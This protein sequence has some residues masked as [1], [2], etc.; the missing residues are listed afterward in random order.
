MPDGKRIIVLNKES[1]AQDNVMTTAQHEVGHAVL[2]ETVKNKPEAAIALGTSLLEELKNSKDITFTSSRFLDRFNQYV[3]DA[4]I[5][6]ADTME[7]V[8]TLASEGLESGDIVFNEKATTKIGDFIRRALSAMG[9]NVKFKTG[10]DVLNFVRDYNRSVQKGKGLSR[11]LEKAA[12][13]G[14]EVDIKAPTDI[15]AEATDI[16]AK[17]SKKDTGAIASTSAQD[18]AVKSKSKEGLTKKEE[19]NLVEQVQLMAIEALGYKQG[20]GTVSRDKALGFVNDYIPGILRRFKPVK[21]IDGKDVPQQISTFV[22]RNIQPKQAKFYEQEIGTKSV[23][24]SISDER[25][26]ELESIED[27]SRGSVIEV[28][29]DV[30]LVD[31]IK[32]DGKPL[33]LPFKDKVRGFVTKQLKNV[34]INSEKFRK[35]VF[36]PSKD[37]VDFI[38][39]DL[40]GNPK[41]FRE[42]LN[43]NPTFYKGLSI[44]D[45]VAIDDGRVKKGQ[46]RLFTEPN[47]RLTKQADIEK[48]MMQGRIPYLTTTQQK[49]GAVLYNRLNPK[50]AAVINNFFGSTPQNNSNRKRAIAKAIANKFIAEAT[51]STEAFKAKPQ[52]DKAKIAERLQVSQQA[53]FSK[54]SAGSQYNVDSNVINAGYKPIKPGV[55]GVADLSD[56]L[57]NDLTK[58]FGKNASSIRS[59]IKFSGCW[60][61]LHR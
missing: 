11:G 57:V 2:F 44:T 42:F 37:F 47:R 5:S 50:V 56:F 32:I 54:R 61:L 27:T 30:K 31:N 25:Q 58:V 21:N 29:T 20:K 12:T 38:V 41:Q 40:I 22:Y 24:T 53:K 19:D 36:K 3:E 15:E 59:C 39:K 1:A 33:D 4:D 49:A 16:V 17:E 52:L 43:S 28:D 8:L 13:K 60:K 34:D 48:F 45:L 35:Q 23:E 55:E 51:P 6:K 14:A 10:K 9:L 46:P 26:K 18:L 7:E